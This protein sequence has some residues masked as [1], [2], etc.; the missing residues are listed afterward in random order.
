[1]PPP[2][3]APRPRPGRPRSSSRR[4]RGPATPWRGRA[5]SSGTAWDRS[6]SVPPETAVT[7]SPPQ[8]LVREEGPVVLEGRPGVVLHVSAPVELVGQELQDADHRPL[9]GRPEP[10]GDVFGERPQ[11]RRQGLVEVE[12]P[13]RVEG[14]LEERGQVV[15]EAVE[16]ERPEVVPQVAPPAGLHHLRPLHSPVPPPDLLGLVRAPRATARDPVVSRVGTSGKGIADL[17]SKLLDGR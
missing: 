8:L 5:Y 11:V 12:P 15:G 10:R 17:A 9:L 16:G 4:R 7:P 14:E 13:V 2:R 6:S 3:P 1:A